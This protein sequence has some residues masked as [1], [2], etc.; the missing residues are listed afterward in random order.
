M[1]KDIGHIYWIKGFKGDD[2]LRELYLQSY[3]GI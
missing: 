3:Y 1:V 2:S